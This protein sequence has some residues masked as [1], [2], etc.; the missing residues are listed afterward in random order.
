M[1]IK[2]QTQDTFIPVEIGDLTLK[3]DVSDDSLVTLRKKIDNIQ[4][5]SENIN[6]KGDDAEVLE[7]VKDV[8]RTAYDDV[9]G[10]G[11][12][13]KVYEISPSVIITTQYFLDIGQGIGREMD[14]RGLTLSSHEKAKKYL[15]NK[16]KK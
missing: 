14:E 16:N 12:Y 8:I 9:F 11:T 10:E 7:S 1:A 6:T 4:K 2:I 3:F 15:Q 13:D 5:M